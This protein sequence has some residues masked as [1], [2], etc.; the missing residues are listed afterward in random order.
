MPHTRK[1]LAAPI[2]AIVALAIAAP[3]ASAD[4][5]GFGFP[6]LA[7]GLVPAGLFPLG[8]VGS[9]TGVLGPC[10]HTTAQGQGATGSASPQACAV[11]AFVGPSVG[12]ITSVIGPRIIGPA[13]I[14]ST[15]V[16]A[17]QVIQ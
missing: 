3:S 10:S 8:P 14:G 4:T 1:R 11:L 13:V 12:Q 9:A 7:G 5:T 17:G 6:G 2:V 15:V 16:S